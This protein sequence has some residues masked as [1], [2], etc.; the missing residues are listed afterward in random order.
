MKR[1]IRIEAESLNRLYE[2]KER[3]KKL[4]YFLDVLKKGEQFY[5][6]K[7]V[8]MNKE[9]RKKS[10]EITLLNKSLQERNERLEKIKEEMINLKKVNHNI[11]G[12]RIRV[13]R[14]KES[15]INRLITK[16]NQ[17]IEITELIKQIQEEKE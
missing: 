14:L 12:E 13:R 15:L 2:F 7:M 17:D 11:D 8:E 6:G 3:L 16:Y 10:N 4:L 1:F 5:Q 9:I